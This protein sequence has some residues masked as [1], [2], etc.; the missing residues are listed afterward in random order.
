M[1]SFVNSKLF[2]VLLLWGASS[3][4]EEGNMSSLVLSG[5]QNVLYS[6]DLGRLEMRKLFDIPTHGTYKA[7]YF[8]LSEVDEY[9]FLFESPMQWVGSFDLKSGKERQLVQQASCP[10]YFESTNQFIYAKVV[11][12]DEGFVEHLYS[13]DLSSG[14][15]EKVVNLARGT[16]SQCPIKLDE[17]K[18]IVY[19]SNGQKKEL[20][21][22]NAVE[23]SLTPL[24]MKGGTPV[25]GLSGDKILCLSDGKYYISNLGGGRLKDIPDEL[26]N[27]NNM[28]PI[29]YVA[30]ENS[31]VVQEYRERLF[32]STVTSLWLI[33]ME[34]MKKRLVAENFGVEKKGVVSPE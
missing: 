28:F 20:A 8:N 32:R 3:L 16:A 29:A 14:Q 27:I 34:T 5:G 9:T 18:A 22:Y 17:D 31:V 30:S 24:D 1:K 23:K 26:L 2:F 21:L 25:L 13:M 6:Y 15:S 10:I 11:R 33:D 4:A 12:T 7:N 19:L